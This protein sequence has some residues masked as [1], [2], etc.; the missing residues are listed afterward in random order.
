V[1]TDP[2]H[3]DPTTVPPWLLDAARQHHPAAMGW[4]AAG[5]LA[6]VEVGRKAGPCA[7]TIQAPF[8]GERLMCVLAH[9][10]HG[11]HATAGPTTWTDGLLDPT[12]GE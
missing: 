9:G 11:A 7:A 12:A 3:L 2:E 8:G 4:L 5:Y 6:G 10:H 1:S